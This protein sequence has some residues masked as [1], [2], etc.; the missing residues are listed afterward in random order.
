MEKEH[1]L[2]KEVNEIFNVINGK[3]I[4]LNL[5]MNKSQ[6]AEWD[7]IFH[8]NLIVDLESKYN[9]NFT[10]EE[11]ENLDSVKKVIDKINIQK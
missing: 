2:L 4:E 7:S 3:E 10:I 6:I 5:S 1:R 8:L 11:I 9:L